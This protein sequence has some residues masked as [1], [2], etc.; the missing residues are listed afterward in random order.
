MANLL[1]YWKVWLLVFCLLGAMGAVLLKSSAQGVEVVYVSA[2]SPAQGILKQGMVITRVNTVP[3]KSFNDWNEQTGKLSNS[4]R[5]TVDGREYNFNL[6]QTNSTGTNQEKLGI[7]VLDVSKFNLDFGLDLRGGTRVLL[8]PKTDAL[9]EEIEDAKNV[10]QTRANLYGLKEI[11]FKVLSELGGTNLLE[12]EASGVGSD[13]INNLL[14]KSG[15]FEA[16][17]S[18]P[19]TIKDGVGEFKLYSNTYPVKIIDNE[20]I[21]LNNQKLNKSSKTTIEDIEFEFVNKTADGIVLLGSAYHGKDIEIVYTDAQRSGLQST[22]GGGYNFFF[23]VLVSKQGAERFGKITSGVPE[24]IDILTNEKYLK[25]SEILIFVD[26]Q[27]VSNLRIGS[28]LGGREYTTP[29]ISGSR[30]DRQS[31]LEERLRLQTVLKSGAT[32]VSLETVS[33]DVIPPTLGAGFITSSIYVAGLSGL[34][35]LIIVIVRYRRPKLAIPMFLVTVVEIAIILGIAAIND[36]AIWGAV[37]ILN[38]VLLGV[39][40]MK[41]HEVDV[42]AWVGAIT[43]PLLGMGMAWTIDLPAIGGIIAAIGTGI[44]HQIIIADEAITG[45]KKKVYSIKDKI[46]VAFFI[47]FGAAATIVVAM[48]PLMF[49]VAEFVKGF[50]ITT[51]IG[52]WIGV[53]VTRPAYSRIVEKVIKV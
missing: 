3:V 45:Q 44:D 1:S 18:K 5:M 43:I 11:K 48:L 9:I 27:L 51:I 4:V 33:V 12:I 17:V 31:A 8:K 23:G 38:I 2:A 35:V 39:S 50:A 28:E 47:I 21:E 7:N 42:F 14:S 15:K 34:V 24:F 10:L 29:Q 19:V 46:K 13:V 6:N 25:D 26:D 20:T 37:L 41:K 40:A 32:P 36:G 53:S 16:K 30:E 49:L 22:Q 52:V